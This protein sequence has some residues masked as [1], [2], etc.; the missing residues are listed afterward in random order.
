MR[1]AAAMDLA[2]MPPLCI[3]STSLGSGG[4]GVSLVMGVC[5]AMQAV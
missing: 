5:A 2:L 1:N 3:N 4:A